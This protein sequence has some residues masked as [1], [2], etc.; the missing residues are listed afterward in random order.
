MCHL[1]V[2]SSLNKGHKVGRFWWSIFCI[3]NLFL[4]D[5]LLLNVS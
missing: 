1:F 5:L 2:L 4:F 3:F